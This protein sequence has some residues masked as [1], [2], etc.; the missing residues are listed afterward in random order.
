MHPALQKN[1]F[2]GAIAQYLQTDEGQKS[3]IANNNNDTSNSAA[4]MAIAAT[5]TAAAGAQQE[6]EDFMFG[7]GVNFDEGNE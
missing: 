4:T 5:T 7:H 3:S 2:S 1:T 6:D